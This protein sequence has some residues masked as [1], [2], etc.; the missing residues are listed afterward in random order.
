MLT[1]VLKITIITVIKGK[2]IKKLMEE[3]NPTTSSFI[4]EATELITAYNGIGVTANNANT[5][6]GK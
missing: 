1:Y 2:L 3:A 5:N 6:L 4:P